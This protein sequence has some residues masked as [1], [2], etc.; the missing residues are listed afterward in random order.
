MKVK[1]SFA[2]HCGKNWSIFPYFF[3]IFK[4]FFFDQVKKNI[5]TSLKDQNFLSFNG[6]Q[7]AKMKK[8]IPY[9]PLP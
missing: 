7:L 3:V 5:I 6:S 8:D 9:M 1:K 4:V 2:C